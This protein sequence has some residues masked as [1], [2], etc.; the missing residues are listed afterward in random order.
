M[1]YSR[2]LLKGNIQTI[3]L[4]VLSEAPLHGY[5]IAREI[6]RRSE[7]TLRFG[8]GTIYPALHTLERD[9]LVCSAWDTTRGGP[10]RKIYTL[11][12]SGHQELAKRR[13]TWHAFARTIERVIGGQ[14]D[15]QPI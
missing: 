5:A 10:A 15:A 7:N 2:E 3:I 1:D 14:P 9:R 11:S 4:A 8:E 12:E 13:R 6:E